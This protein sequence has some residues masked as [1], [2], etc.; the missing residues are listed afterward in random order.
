M[1]PTFD[2]QKHHRRSI[3]LKGYDYASPGAYFVTIVTRQRE[4][5]FGEIINGKMQLNEIGKLVEHAWKNLPNHYSNVELGT[6]CIMPNHVHGITVL[7]DTN[8][9]AGHVGAGLR[10]APTRPIKQ[11]GLPEIVRAF[12]SFSARHVNE[13]L[14]SPGVP[15]WQRNYYERVIRDDDE[16]QRIHL[17]IECNPANWANDEE[18]SIRNTLST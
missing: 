5:L 11:H 9:G 4:Y 10:P 2:P 6:F 8:A 14:K 12:K 3:R 13:Y 17:Y 16:H 15:L 7:I 1:K 18:N